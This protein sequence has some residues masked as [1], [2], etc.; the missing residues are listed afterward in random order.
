MSGV[1]GGTKAGLLEVPGLDPTELYSPT[2]TAS[3]TNMDAFDSM[4]AQG[5]PQNQVTP[6]WGDFPYPGEGD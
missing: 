4:A 5:I 1:G 2:C 3:Q 6:L